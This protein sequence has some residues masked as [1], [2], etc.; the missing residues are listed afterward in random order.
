[1]EDMVTPLTEVAVAFVKREGQA[2][3]KTAA[4]QDQLQEWAT[5]LGTCVQKQHELD[6]LRQL[7]TQV[8]IQAQAGQLEHGRDWSAWLA[9]MGG[10]TEAK[11]AFRDRLAAK[12]TKVRADFWEAVGVSRTKPTAIARCLWHFLARARSHALLAG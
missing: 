9:Q 12:D 8:G 6:I 4:V 2:K 3:Y 7:C 10:E 1:M 11:P 5:R